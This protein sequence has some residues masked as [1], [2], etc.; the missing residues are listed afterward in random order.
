[1]ESRTTETGRGWHL[2]IDG[3]RARPGD[4]RGGLRG[5]LWGARGHGD[6][7]VRRPVVLVHVDSDR[8]PEVGGDLVEDTSQVLADASGCGGVG[9]AVD[10]DRQVAVAVDGD[11]HGAEYGRDPHSV[12]AV[13][14]GRGAAAAESTAW[15]REASRSSPGG[16]PSPTFEVSSFA[17]IPSA[18]VRTRSAVE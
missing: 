14:L 17:R 8:C 3:R 9:L 1:M 2:R 12:S 10:V 15:C 13:S 18:A 7:G 16:V 11:V 5:G 6:V 4:V